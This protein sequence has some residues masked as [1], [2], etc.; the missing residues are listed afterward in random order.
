MTVY[1]IVK[2]ESG[3]MDDFIIPLV[4]ERNGHVQTFT[5]VQIGDTWGRL[6]QSF[7]E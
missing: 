2:N 5:P 6:R 3:V 4:N 7:E 1:L